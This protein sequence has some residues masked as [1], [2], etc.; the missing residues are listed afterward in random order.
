MFKDLKFSALWKSALDENP[1]LSLTE[2]IL[3]LHNQP[4]PEV[5][6]VK[7]IRRDDNQ[8]NIP[9]DSEYRQLAIVRR[10]NISL[11][12]PREGSHVS[13]KIKGIDHSYLNNDLARVTN[14]LT[15]ISLC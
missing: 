8:D 12:K 1:D 13:F 2:F 9:T 4:L 6:K 11:I 15:N 7:R 3:G 10:R 14:S 5:V